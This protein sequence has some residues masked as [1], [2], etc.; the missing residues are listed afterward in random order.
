MIVY[1]LACAKGHDFEGWFRDSAGYEAQAA[2]GKLVCPVCNSKKI[3]KAPM[4]PAVSG[5]KSKGSA[6]APDLRQMR[7][8]LT[9]LR[10]QIETNAENVGREFP[11]EA[12]KIHYG[13]IEERPIY[14]EASIAE[15]RE[16]VEEGVAV[17][18]MPPD[19]SEAN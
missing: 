4:A 1:S 2:A 8:F 6:P 15:A 9:G 3:A 16:L 19:L 7:Q 18:P 12:R 13:E 11:E 5:T 14:G 17:A 10:K